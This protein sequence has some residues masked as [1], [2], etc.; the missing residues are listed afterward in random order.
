MNTLNGYSKSTLT[1]SYVLT[2]SGGHKA[3]GNSDGNIPLNNGTVNTNLRSEYARYLLGIT[4]DI[5][6]TGDKET[7][8][9]V[10]IKFCN[11]K[12]L[13]NIITIWKNLGSKTASYTGN[14]SN[15]TSSMLYRYECRNNGWDETYFKTLVA[16][17]SYA[18]LVAHTEISQ[19][20]HGLL[21]IWLRGGGTAYKISADYPLTYNAT[22]HTK[23]DIRICYETTNVGTSTYPVNLSP[24]TEIDNAGIYSSGYFGYGIFYGNA[25]TATTATNVI[26]TQHT[27]SDV[28]WPIV[29]S[30][31]NNTNNATANQ[32]YKSYNHL[33]YNPKNKRLTV[34]GIIDSPRVNT[35][36]V[37]ATNTG[38][39]TDVGMIVEG[40]ANKIGF[41]IGSGN[42][43]R[44][45]YDYTNSKW[46][47]YKDDSATYITDWNGVGSSTTPVYFTGGKP[48]A[49]AYSLNKTVPSN[50]VFTDT[51]YAKYVSYLL[52]ATEGWYRIASSD[53]YVINCIGLFQIVGTLSGYHTA[54]TMSA[55]TSYN[56]EGATNLT[57]LS[58]HHY[59]N[60]ALSKVRIVYKS[61]RWSGQYA[62]LE[63]YNADGLAQNL[64]V[65]MIDGT[66]WTLLTTSTTGDIPSGYT[67]KEVILEDGT[68]TSEKFR[69]NL[70]EIKETLRITSTS[71]NK[72]IL[73]G[74]QGGSGT[75]KPFVMR[76]SNGGVE[77][78]YGD[79]WEDNGGNLT[80]F[81]KI[82]GTTLEAKNQVRCRKDLGGTLSQFGTYQHKGPLEVG[83]SSNAMCLALGVTDDDYGYIQSKGESIT[84]TGSLVLQPSGGK[85]LYG[86]SKYTIWHSG[87]DGA[88]SGLAADTVDSWHRSYF[89]NNYNGSRHYRIQ[90]GLGGEDKEWKTIAKT[91][92]VNA[93]GSVTKPKQE[94]PTSNHWTA[95]M[96]KGRIFRQL[97]NYNQGQVIEYP[98]EAIFHYTSGTS[99]IDTATLY[100][101][102]FAK[103]YDNIRIVKL[104]TNVYELQ[105]R[106]ITSWY[107]DWIEFQGS[108]TILTC[109]E[110]LQTASTTGTVVQTADTA[111]VLTQDK[112]SFAYT[113]QTATKA[114]Q[115]SAG[116]VIKDI[117]LK[118]TGDTMTGPLTINSNVANSVLDAFCKNGNYTYLRFGKSTGTNN[119]GE[120]MFNYVSDQST[121]RYLQLGFYDNSVSRLKGYTNGTWTI[122]DAVIFTE[123]NYANYVPKKD[124]TGASGTWDINITGT[125]SKA[126]CVID[127]GDTSRTVKIGYKGNGLTTTSF[128]AAYGPDNGDGSVSIKDLSVSNAKAVLGVPT[129]LSQLTNDSGF[130]TGGPYL[131]LS[132][133]TMTGVITI[134]ADNRLG[135]KFG[136][137]HLT[138]L[139]NQLIWQSTEAIRFGSAD[140]DWNQW[141][142]LKYDH[143]KKSVYLGLADGSIFTANTAQSEGTLYLPGISNVYLGSITAGGAKLTTTTE[144]TQMI[145]DAAFD[146]TTVAIP[147]IDV[148]VNGTSVLTDK[149]ANITV[150]SLGLN[151]ASIGLGNVQNTAFYNKSVSVNGTVEYFAGNDS[152]ESFQVYAPTYSGLVGQLL[153][154]SGSNKAPI[155]TSLIP[156]QSITNYSTVTGN[157]LC[158]YDNTNGTLTNNGFMADNTSSAVFWG[159]SNCKVL[160]AAQAGQTNALYMRQYY[161][162]WGNWFKILNSGNTYINDN[163]ITINSTSLTLK[164]LSSKSHSD[165]TD[166]TTDDKIIPTM[167]FIKYWNGAYNSYGSSN[168]SYCNH[169]PFGSAAIYTATGSVTEDSTNLVTS[170]GIYSFV[171]GFS[172]INKT[173]TV[174]SVTLS[175]GGGISIDNTAA[176]T[177]SGTRIITNIGVRST[178]ISG[179][180]L[181]VNTNGTN[182]DLT[183]PYAISAEQLNSNAGGVNQP[184]YF[185]GGK[186]VACNRVAMYSELPKVYWAVYRIRTGS[187]DSTPEKLSGNW[188]FVSGTAL[189]GINSGAGLAISYPVGYDYN[190]TL[191][192]ATFASGPDGV[193]K[194]ITIVNTS[195]PIGNVGDSINVFVGDSSYISLGGID[196]KIQFL[197]FESV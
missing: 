156:M 88:E 17:C 134:A 83:R 149:V 102:Q 162:E 195:T 28:E 69:G 148:Q 136:T 45:I 138:S 117:Y 38:G 76:A 62:Y 157:G 5:E 37:V 64:Q 101:P 147:V 80:I 124:G 106:M 23:S 169:G 99:L 60:K 74:N 164:T 57:I 137:S 30:N 50:A 44:G 154:S 100:L 25:T 107:S 96:I 146:P 128:F 27:D 139:S 171:T 187:P 53:Q 42:V 175:A 165:W 63:V 13:P 132:G 181:R 4:I 193:G 121:A 153:V 47:F 188:N 91:V 143:S 129:K 180:Y 55:G 77:F 95:S 43:N 82:N 178:T 115:D 186:P 33:S 159:K 29:W 108:G 34:G 54:F 84:N 67:S 152:L 35:K 24:K 71:G 197:C 12:E 52:P 68:V 98:F 122:N 94:A 49:C 59:L 103:E 56:T 86:P 183:I 93:D 46:I 112:A 41:M 142:G 172:G 32:L 116:N 135:L 65:K 20:D 119:C 105:V 160:L 48:V 111:T 92:V 173:G 161:T 182:T 104:E 127:Y 3:I 144:V 184:I 22:D 26:V 31:Q 16:Q 19:R 90:F 39:G 21:I 66:G 131:P 73:M 1:D 70:A 185:S 11:R 9:P 166:N 192:S 7:Y 81:T 75:N 6:V 177:T 40:S 170:K 151:K 79:S 36:L 120:L 125:S 85:L 191:I 87:N 109:Y 163:S 14:H 58:T 18:P 168:L 130:I 150:A 51:S 8:Y 72:Y 158:G 118:K 141:A 145:A 194:Y 133:G 110:S 155:W 89:P 140:W 15:G 190:N 78:A 10:S 179:N 196:V 189:V 113:A 97:G 114:T 176:I 61:D 126:T 167:S 174:T 2:A 123:N